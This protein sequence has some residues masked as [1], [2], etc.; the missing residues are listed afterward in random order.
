MVFVFLFLTQLSQQD[1]LCTYVSFTPSIGLTQS[2]FNLFACPSSHSPQLYCMIPSVSSKFEHHFSH[3]NS[4]M[5]LLLTVSQGQ[6]SN[7]KL[8]SCSLPT[9]PRT[10]DL[11]A[12]LPASFLFPFVYIYLVGLQLPVFLSCTVLIFFFNLLLA[13]VPQHTNRLLFLLLLIPHSHPTAAPAPAG[14]FFPPPFSS[15]PQE[16]RHRLDTS[17]SW[18]LI[19]SSLAGSGWLG[20]LGLEW[21]SISNCFP[22]GK[23]KKFSINF[24]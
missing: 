7:H 16:P 18:G 17:L 6:S 10:S 13:R 20:V 2:F 3:P 22:V 8:S 14:A 9:Q 23:K 1:H 21:R 19:K 5:M 15:R 4:Q 11:P 24:L 12:C